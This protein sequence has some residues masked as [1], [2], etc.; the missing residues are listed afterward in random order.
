MHCYQISPHVYLESFDENAV[1][2]V[3]DRDVMVTV[4]QAAAQIFTLAWEMVG[5]RSF[6]RV[7]CINFLLKH[8]ELTRQDAEV[9]M[10]ALLRFALTH[11]LVL[12]R[13]AT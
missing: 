5:E 1:M 3:V 13:F 6:S 12:K 7:D 8:Y 10:R 4:N 2:L 9:Q 11:G